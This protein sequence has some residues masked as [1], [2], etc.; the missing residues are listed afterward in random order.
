MD[1]SSSRNNKID[2]KNK[3]NEQLDTHRIQNTGEKITTN[4]GL[5]VANNENTL[6]AGDRGPV[7]MEDFHFFQKQMHVDTEQIPERFVHAR[8]L[9]RRR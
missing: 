6:K 5:K 9:G 4:E 7:L 3:K 2:E 8:G 1:Q